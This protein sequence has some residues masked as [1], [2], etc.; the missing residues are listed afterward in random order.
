VS[1]LSIS[2]VQNH[3][4]CPYIYM[5]GEAPAAIL[6][7]RSSRC[8]THAHMPHQPYEQPCPR[9]LERLAAPLARSSDSALRAPVVG[10]PA[11]KRTS[12]TGYSRLYRIDNGYCLPTSSAGSAR[13]RHGP[14]QPGSR[15]VRAKTIRP[16]ASRRASTPLDASLLDRQASLSSAS[17]VGAPTRRRWSVRLLVAASTCWCW[18]VAVVAGIHRA[19]VTRS[20]HQSPAVRFRSS[21]GLNEKNLIRR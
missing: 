11:W 3:L 2:V 10:W 4:Q 9:K 1:P 13:P 7:L 8:D 14:D 16:A 17:L 21:F 18:A 19:P 5:G 20:R 6:C 12:S 15:G